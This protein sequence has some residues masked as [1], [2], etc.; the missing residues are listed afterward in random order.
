M[1]TNKQIHF[2]VNEYLVNL[3]LNKYVPCTLHCILKSV[4]LKNIL[5]FE[6]VLKFLYKG[7]ILEG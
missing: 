2:A 1:N 5:D 3:F 6:P 7:S 4:V